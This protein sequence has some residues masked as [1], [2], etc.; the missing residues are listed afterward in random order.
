IPKFNLPRKYKIS[1]SSGRDNEG[2][3][4]FKDL[5]FVARPD[6]TFDVY[7]GGGF[8][9]NGSRFGILIDE[10]ID[11]MDIPYYILGY[12]RDVYMKYGDYEHRAK[13]RSRLSSTSSAKTPSA[14]PS[15][16]PSKKPVKKGFP[17][18][19]S[20]KNRPLPRAAPTIRS[21]PISAS[22]SR[23]K[24]ASTTSNTSP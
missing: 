21:F 16:T 1:F 3:A 23:N 24:K 10:G 5:G 2:H 12:G 18:S 22:A 8:G 6:H 19:P 11:P 13:N 17:S 14:K 20:K 4:T 7:A 9:V 15:A